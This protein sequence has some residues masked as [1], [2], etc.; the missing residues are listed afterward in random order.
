MTES[1]SVESDNVQ[2]LPL[3]HGLGLEAASLVK[4]IH[5]GVTRKSLGPP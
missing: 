1:L 4:A 2:N 5:S 3:P